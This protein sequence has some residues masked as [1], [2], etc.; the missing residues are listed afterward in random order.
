MEEENRLWILIGKKLAD[1][2]TEEEL[3]QLESFLKENPDWHYYIEILSA[4]WKL[5]E[6]SGTQSE[7]V[8]NK[9]LDRI[10]MEKRMKNIKADPHSTP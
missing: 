3:K 4:W 8:L 2:A 1:E 9:L 6:Y 10:E 7:K 5:V